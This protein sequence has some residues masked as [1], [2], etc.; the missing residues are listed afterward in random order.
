MGSYQ[1]RGGEPGDES[2]DWL[3]AEQAV[4]AEMAARRPK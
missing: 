1:R 4:D 2:E 3:E